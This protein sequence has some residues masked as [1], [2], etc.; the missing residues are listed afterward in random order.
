MKRHLSL[1]WAASLVLSGCV[2]ETT[3]IGKNSVRQENAIDNAAASKTRIQLGMG[4]LNKGEMASAKYN[5]EKAI[6]LAPSSAEAYLAMA[7]Y[8]QSVGDNLSAQKTYEQLVSSHGNDPD[9]LNN[10]GTFLCR[11]HNYAQADSMFMRAVAQPRYLKMD[12]TYENAALCAVES[13]KKDKA[14][15][16]YRLALGYNPQK[17]G[18][19]LDLAEIALNEHNPTDAESWLRAFRKKANDTAQSL[20]LSIRTAQAQGRIADIHVFGQS[21]VQQFPSSVQAKRY[22]NNDY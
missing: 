18:L 13:G 4:Y 17:V 12:D 6:E 10:Y 20:W 3:I 5:F 11:N 16:Y 9:V 7:Y 8:Y 22:Q 1:L 15:E 21:L 14:K 19:M 2:T